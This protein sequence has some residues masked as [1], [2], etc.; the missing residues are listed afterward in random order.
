M[1]GTPVLTTDWGA[2]SETVVHGVTG[3]RC[4]SFDDFLWAADN[5]HRLDPAAC[6]AWATRWKPAA[7]A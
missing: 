3:F 5:A 1:C 6:R 7:C 4:R 2:F